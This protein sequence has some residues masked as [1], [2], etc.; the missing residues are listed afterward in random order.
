MFPEPEKALNL[1]DPDRLREARA[2]LQDIS[3]KENPDLY[4]IKSNQYRPVSVFLLPGMRKELL[5]VVRPIASATAAS[6]GH[7][8]LPCFAA[9]PGALHPSCLGWSC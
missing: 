6:A 7:L 4:I 1:S 5:E 2:S 3:T 8:C 9:V